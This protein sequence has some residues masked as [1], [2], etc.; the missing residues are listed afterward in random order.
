MR[1]SG[2]VSIFTGEKAWEVLWKCT[3]FERARWKPFFR[4]MKAGTRCGLSLLLPKLGVRSI[5]D[6][7]CGVGWKTII[8][9]EMGYQVEGSDG[10][11]FAVRCASQLARE[12]GLHLKFFDARWEDLGKMRPERYDCVYNDAFAWVPTRRALAASAM[13]IRSALKDGGSFIF[14]GAHQWSRKVSRERLIDRMLNQMGRF[15]LLQP[16]N[17]GGTK[18]TLL[19]LRERDGE[20]IADNHVFL[21]E[22]RGWARVEVAK[23]MDL[24]TWSW[25]DYV[26]VLSRSGFRKIYSVRSRNHKGKPYIFNV[27]EK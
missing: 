21:I 2:A 26:D 3:W 17:R 24:C 11:G 8:L 4:Q 15:Q 10:C 27:A 23:I 5:L 14:V 6:C 25:Q 13:G 19:K 1:S 7:S 22:E 20:G 16:F 12:E 18:M 9:A